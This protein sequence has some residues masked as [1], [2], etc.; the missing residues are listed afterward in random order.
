[1]MLFSLA[2]FELTFYLVCGCWTQTH[3]VSMEHPGAGSSVLMPHRGPWQS[4]PP[5]LG[6]ALSEAKQMCFCLEGEIA[7]VKFTSAAQCVSVFSAQY[8]IFNFLQLGH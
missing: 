1:M 8:L 5:A 2:S 3:L 6:A 7:C 4:F